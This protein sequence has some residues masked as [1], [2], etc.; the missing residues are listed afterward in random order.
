M[1]HVDTS[2]RI[3]QHLL[4][5][6]PLIYERRRVGLHALRY[7]QGMHIVARKL[8]REQ[9]KEAYGAA[10]Q[11]STL[12]F[13]VVAQHGAEEVHQHGAERELRIG[14]VLPAQKV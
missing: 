1:L 3:S 8:L 12:T 10:L 11:G 2:F 5:R 4:S 6:N 14:A 13:D 9:G 7:A